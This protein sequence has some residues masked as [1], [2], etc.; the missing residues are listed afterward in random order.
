MKIYV[1]SRKWINDFFKELDS[2]KLN[3]LKNVRFISINTLWTSPSF[4]LENCPI[5]EPYLNETLVLHFDDVDNNYLYETYLGCKVKHFSEQQAKAIKVF[6]DKCIED[7]KDIVVHCTAG[8]S[9]SGAVG[10]SIEAY[11]NMLYNLN[12]KNDIWLKPELVSE[13]NLIPNLLVKK[14]LRKEF[15]LDYAKQ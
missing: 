6:V 9:R 5:P 2:N 8:I 4:P 3:F 1:K 10:V 7:K 13:N 12:D 15:G 14:L 11:L